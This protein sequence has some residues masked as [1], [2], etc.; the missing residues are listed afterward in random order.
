MPAD[1]PFP[2]RPNPL[3]F[4]KLGAAPEPLGEP[5]EPCG[6]ENRDYR[7][8]QEGGLL[9]EVGTAAGAQGTVATTISGHLPL[10]AQQPDRRDAALAGS[11]V[12]RPELDHVPGGGTA[13]PS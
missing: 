12:R 8:P 5:R 2:Q 3:V 1:S 4:F 7:S 13:R 9:P 10:W 6:P 11:F